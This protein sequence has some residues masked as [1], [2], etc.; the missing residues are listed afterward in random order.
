MIATPPRSSSRLWLRIAD[1]MA[2]VIL[3]ATAFL[4]MDAATSRPRPVSRTHV[5]PGIVTE[6]RAESIGL[7][8]VVTV[9]LRS[10]DVTVEVAPVTEGP[11]DFRLVWLPT[12]SR[13]SQWDVAVSGGDFSTTWGRY[14]LAGQTGHPDFALICDGR[15]VQRQTDGAILWFDEHQTGHLE[16]VA[17]TSTAWTAARWGVG[18]SQLCVVDGERIATIASE[19]K[20][21]DRRTLVGLDRTGCVLTLATFEWATAEDSAAWFVAQGI[22]RAM[23]LG[24]AEN[25][26]MVINSAVA[27]NASLAKNGP[28]RF[29]THA[30]GIRSAR[31]DEPLIQTMRDRVL[32]R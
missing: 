10:P 20:Q 1:G 16:P 29:I 5:A 17:G 27:G 4:A 23:E 7:T 8:Q 12:L 19:S 21:H 2:V 28:R 13:Q 9:D 3:V 15:T 31:T 30:L 22:W 11:T 14:A 24:T 25:A 6:C 26:G 32:P 18:G